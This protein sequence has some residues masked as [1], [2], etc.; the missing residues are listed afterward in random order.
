MGVASFSRVVLKNRT[1]CK[2]FV[3]VVFLL[4]FFCCCCCCF[5]F[6]F[7][8]FVYTLIRWEVRRG[9]CEVGEVTD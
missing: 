9:I 5:V 1:C 3:V 7:I 8:I 4:L 6:S 2:Q